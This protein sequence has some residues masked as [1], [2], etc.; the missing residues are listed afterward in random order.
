MAKE[1]F[2]WFHFLNMAVG[3]RRKGNVY[4][5]RERSGRDIVQGRVWSL[6]GV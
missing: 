2:T 5:G 3:V 1:Q 4:R 6:S